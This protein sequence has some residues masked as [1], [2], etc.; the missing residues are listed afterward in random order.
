VLNEFPEG[1]GP[2]NFVHRRII[3]AAGG[4][5]TGGVPGAVGGF[6][7][8]GGAAAAG[9]R[10]A[11][12]GTLPGDCPPGFSETRSGCQPLQTTTGRALRGLGP[13]GGP[14]INV[15]PVFSG[16]GTQLVGTGTC[17]P[18]FRVDPNTGRCRLFL[19]DQPG[20]NGGPAAG[21]VVGMSGMQPMVE[22]RQRMDCLPGMVLGRDNLCYSKRDIRNSDRKWPKGRAPLL[23]GGERNAITKASRAAKKI[24]T[25][26]KSLQRMGMLKKPKRGI[27]VAQA[28]KVLH[29]QS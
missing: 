10:T 11:P 7:G 19:G 2:L 25:T 4:F 9:G 29:H 6:V 28:K 24:E 23:T 18:P 8:G 20:P 17:I 27:T 3:S 13:L 14:A 21:A 16:G 1:I 26:T 5:L 12:F 15:D 22:T